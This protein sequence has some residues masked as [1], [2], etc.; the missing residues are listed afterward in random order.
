LRPP[1]PPPA[2]A[3]ASA[4]AAAAA[5]GHSTLTTYSLSALDSRA[6]AATVRSGAMPPGLRTY[7]S[8]GRSAAE[9]EGSSAQRAWS[10]HVFG[11][12]GG[13][14]AARGDDPAGEVEA[15]WDARRAGGGASGGGRRSTKGP[16]E[17]AEAE[18][19]VV[20]SRG[21]LGGA[22]AFAPAV[23]AA[24]TSCEV[25]THASPRRR[26]RTTTIAGKFVPL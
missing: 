11:A 18:A 4:A 13:A 26:R 6:Y 16:E 22:S 21:E 3:A 17:E 2:P 8:C 23:A 10:G 5:D 25:V 9:A 24:P 1:P 7:R 12:A 14:E 15:S 19:A 20:A